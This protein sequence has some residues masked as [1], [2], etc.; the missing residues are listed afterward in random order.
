M[1]SVINEIVEWCY[2]EGDQ[3][4]APAVSDQRGTP[5][6]KTLF[7]EEEVTIAA[8]DKTIGNAAGMSLF[9][10]IEALERNERKRQLQE[11][12]YHSVHDLHTIRSHALDEWAGLRLADGGDRNVIAHGGRLLADIDTIKAHAFQKERVARWKMAFEEK[13]GVSFDQT[14][15]T[16]VTMQPRFIDTLDMRAGALTLRA[17]QDSSHQK[18][19]LK[20]SIIQKCDN[21]ISSW[22]NNP[23]CDLF[24]EEG[25]KMYE[26][27]VSEWNSIYYEECK[28]LQY[29]FHSYPGN[30]AY[31][32]ISLEKALS[33]CL[34]VICFCLF[35][36]FNNTH[37][38]LAAR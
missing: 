9:R 24:D 36:L 7:A 33:G 12:M 37:M 31:A 8:D 22:K 23:T 1:R 26:Q 10:R 3:V 19:N 20:R 34:L 29:F 30:G 17:F 38:P 4:H 16:Y 6:K 18:D 13:Y 11:Q 21:I 2:P 32:N 28:Y 25:M 5:Q 27:L 35:I 15:E 14:N